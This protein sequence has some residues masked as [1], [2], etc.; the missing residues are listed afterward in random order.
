MEPNV[1]P[2]D[3]GRSSAQ[4]NDSGLIAFVLLSRILGVLAD[5]MQ[6]RHQYLQGAERFDADIILRAAKQL[7][8][9]ARRVGST[10]ERL[11]ATALPAIAKLK[12][13]SYLLIGRVAADQLLVHDPIANRPTRGG[14]SVG[15]SRQD[16]HHRRRSAR[17]PRTMITAD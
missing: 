9:K 16:R 17:M 12:D 6:L 1:S 4:P 2:I 15:L 13:D 3:A 10:W 11:S 7:S 14:Y 8:L 5:P